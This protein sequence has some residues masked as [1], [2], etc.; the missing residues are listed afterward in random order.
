MGGSPYR[1][2]K[3]IMIT[4]CITTYN[5]LPYLKL[6]IQSVRKYSHF[7]NMPL[8]VHAENCTDGTNEWLLENAST[9]ALTLLIEEGNDPPRGIG[10]GMNLCASKV[11]TE[12]INFIH[13]DFFVTPDWDLNLYRVFEK[14]P[15]EKLWVNSHRVEP[16]MFNNPSSRPG[17][18][19]VPKD[20]F[21]EL[22]TNFN[23]EYF[24]AWAKEFSGLNNFE[25]PKGEGVSGLVRK[26][27]WDEIGGNDSQ[28]APAWWEDYDLF[29]RMRHAGFRFVLPSTS[30][31]YHFG[32]RSSH[33]PGDDFTRQ[34][35]RN[36][37]LEPRGAERFYKKWGGLPV[38]DQYGMI[39]GVQS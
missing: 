1:L 13:S 14:Y 20:E 5:T 33:F 24:V 10:G 39:S 4:T 7:S 19:V 12:Y 38:F 11:T 23:E 34:S 6:A 30:V 3:F 22:H 21:G 9:Y 26:R 37:V 16:N 2:A 36:T 32:A 35:S 28:F 15:D 17:T 25:I 27:D 18:I 8:I 29:L 31:V